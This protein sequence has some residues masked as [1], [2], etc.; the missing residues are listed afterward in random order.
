MLTHFFD[1]FSIVVKGSN[2]PISLVKIH[3]VVTTFIKTTSVC[4]TMQI[5]D[6]LLFEKLAYILIN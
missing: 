1:C 5:V 3:A 2:L 6:V 4:K